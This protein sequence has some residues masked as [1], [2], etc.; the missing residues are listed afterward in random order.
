[1]NPLIIIGVI[2]IILI[3]VF[4][5][6]YYNGCD[7]GKFF[8][9]NEFKCKTCKN[10]PRGKWYDPSKSCK[11]FSDKKCLD[12]SW[13]E[14][15][16]AQTIIFGTETTNHSC[17]SIS[18]C[19]RECSDGN[20]LSGL[21]NCFSA[22]GQSA[23]C[24]P[25]TTCSSSQID[26]NDIA[27][28]GR[29]ARSNIFRSRFTNG[30]WVPISC[31]GDN[32]RV[33]LDSNYIRYN[34]DQEYHIRFYDDSNDLTLSTT[35]I[36]SNLEREYY[37]GN[38]PSI[39]TT[40]NSEYIWNT[41][42]IQNFNNDLS[43]CSRINWKIKNRTLNSIQNCP[44]ETQDLIF[45]YKPTT[46]NLN[47]DILVVI[48]ENGKF[49]PGT[50]RISMNDIDN[51]VSFFSKVSGYRDRI[52]SNFKITDIN[53]FSDNVLTSNNNFNKYFKLEL[54]QLNTNTGEYES[55]GKYLGKK[56][57]TGNI[58]FISVYDSNSFNN[59]NLKFNF[60]HSETLCS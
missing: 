8:S 3:L 5:Y 36:G 29:E 32:D 10:C 44:F 4:V 21:T 33:C 9:I 30:R 53:N 31:D 54:V 59:N 45:I 24:N 38:R 20:Y 22:R 57:S 7:Q 43:N 52:Y 58:P 51:N 17:S 18:S 26:I 14:C 48:E 41:I 56:I 1:M 6:L 60:I 15:N 40:L 47:A 42:S 50:I 35:S 39:I 28:I 46:N 49:I 37:R 11:G 12:Y 16:S 25:C 2:L 19:Y 13:P 34:D 23:V 55:T 27:C